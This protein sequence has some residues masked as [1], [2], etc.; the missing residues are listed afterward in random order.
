MN[1]SAES[2]TVPETVSCGLLI[3]ARIIA[4]EATSARLVRCGAERQVDS[5]FQL[6]RSP[7]MT[8]GI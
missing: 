6:E 7:E 3:L 4:R 5:D 8:V 2:L 1:I